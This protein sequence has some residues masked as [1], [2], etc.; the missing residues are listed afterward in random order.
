MPFRRHVYR[1]AE[2]I[3]RKIANDSGLETHIDVGG[4]KIYPLLP[5]FPFIH[6]DIPLRICPKLSTYGYTVI[7]YL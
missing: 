3:L 7:I 5:H 4:T 2:I 6:I 1:L